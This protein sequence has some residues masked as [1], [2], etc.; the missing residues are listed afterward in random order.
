MGVEKDRTKQGRWTRAGASDPAGTAAAAVAAHEAAPDAH[1]G[2]LTP[3]AGNAAYQPLDSD[4]TAL[5]GL[6]STAGLVEQTGAAAYTKRLIGVANA[7]DIPARSDADTRYSA[8]AHNHAGVY[9]PAG[10]AA[11]AQAASQPLDADLTALAGLNATAGLVEQTGAAAFTKRL[12]GVANSTDVPTR[13]DA[14]TRY[15]TAGH[16]HAQLHDR[17]HAITSAS[18]HTAGNWKVIYT[19]GSGAVIELALGAS[20]TFLKANGASSAPTFEAPS[21]S[22]S[23]ASVAF[24]DGDTAR[25]ATIADAAVTA[26]SKII[27]SVR[28]PDTVAASDPGYIYH[29]NVVSIGS[30]TFDVNVV[31]LDWSGQDCTEIPP[32][33]TVTL[34]YQVA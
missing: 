2:Y 11:A 8:A 21:V 18:D 28:R 32:N 13:A 34:Y 25:R 4:L 27:A 26:A 5:A 16:T 9:D 23:S 1:P 6:N 19:D 24:T 17:Q 15:A 22:I 7:T 20:G 14:D 31:C 30:G 3:A 10:S 33:E 29:A 12:I